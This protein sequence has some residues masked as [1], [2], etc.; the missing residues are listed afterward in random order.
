MP[1]LYCVMSFKIMGQ[2]IY[3]PPKVRS[4]SMFWNPNRYLSQQRGSWGQTPTSS[5]TLSWQ[6]A[7]RTGGLTWALGLHLQV[8]MCLTSYHCSKGELPHSVASDSCH[9]SALN[10]GLSGPTWDSGVDTLAF[11]AP[12][13]WLKLTCI[14]CNNGGST[15]L[16]GTRTNYYSCGDKAHILPGGSATTVDG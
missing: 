10:Q 13:W 7:W 4:P 6:L 1:S 8:W 2:K 5:R 12:G 15:S 3:I 14:S 11:P 16:T 9:I